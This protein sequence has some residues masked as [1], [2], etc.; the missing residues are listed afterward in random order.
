M[1]KVFIGFTHPRICEDLS[2][3][4]IIFYDICEDL[5]NISFFTNLMDE[6]VK[7]RSKKLDFIFNDF[8]ISRAVDLN[9]NNYMVK[10]IKSFYLHFKNNFEIKKKNGIK[11]YL[12]KIEDN[13]VSDVINC[14]SGSGLNY[15]D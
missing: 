5:S 13:K 6:L 3:K 9:S 12:L 7:N 10:N 14:W 2:S 8:F 1:Y 15:L 4:D 11:F